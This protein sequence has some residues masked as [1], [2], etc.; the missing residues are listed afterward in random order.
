MIMRYLIRYASLF[1]IFASAL[2]ASSSTIAQAAVKH[3]PSIPR[4]EF[5]P[6]PVVSAPP[7]E[8]PADVLLVATNPLP[9]VEAEPAPLP[10]EPA[11]LPASVFETR[12]IVSYYGYPKIGG[13]GELGLH[14]PANA[15]VRI[16][17]LA[18]D[19]DALNGDRDAVGALHLIVDVAQA[20]QTD[21]GL[22]LE[23]MD[24]QL[25]AEYVEIARDYEILLFV[26]LQIGWSDPL[27]DVK[28]LEWF[29]REP[30]VH[31]ALDPEFATQRFGYAPGTVIGAL[32]ADEVNEVQSYL[33]ELV[34]DQRIPPKILVLHQFKPGMLIDP[35]RFAD[36]AE[37]EIT[38]DMDGFGGIWAKTSGFQR[39]AQAT[40]A[41]R[42]AFKLFYRWDVPVMSTQQVVD[43]NVDYVIYQ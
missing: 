17:E 39:Y 27:E 40:Y 37:V 34:L 13:M 26:D 14:D 20:K 31:L 30:F 36:V 3:Q 10:A 5:R 4:V 15:A 28:R 11:P 22:Y 24:E 19:Y 23:K 32:D 41:E 8:E 35:E 43:L 42:S 9:P 21:D 16:R 2:L 25:I 12:Q 33:A 6:D 38:I 18:A 29:L 7:D 1:L